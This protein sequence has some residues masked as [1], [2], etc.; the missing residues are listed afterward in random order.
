MHIH[1]Q[2]AETPL[3]LFLCRGDYGELRR[4]GHNWAKSDSN[5]YLVCQSVL[6]VLS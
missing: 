5:L 4:F 2:D 1:T 3:L 6:A